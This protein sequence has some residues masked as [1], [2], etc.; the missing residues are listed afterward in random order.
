MVL[1][2]KDQVP[3]FKSACF[4]L[5]VNQVFLVLGRLMHLLGKFTLHEAVHF[6]SAT[7][8]FKHCLKNYFNK[9]NSA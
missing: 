9:K 1:W 7:I 5:F 8:T 2:N 4:N 6:P 3:Y